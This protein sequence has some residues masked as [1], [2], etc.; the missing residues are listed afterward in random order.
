MITDRVTGR[1]TDI[2][3]TCLNVL[4]LVRVLL[5]IKDFPLLKQTNQASE[6]TKRTRLSLVK[7]KI[8]IGMTCSST[9]ETFNYMKKFVIKLKSPTQMKMTVQK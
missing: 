8:S 5:L 3:K 1:V 7:V 9:T 4:L 2:I 6:Y